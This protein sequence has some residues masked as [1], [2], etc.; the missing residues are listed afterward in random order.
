MTRSSPL[1]SLFDRHSPVRPN[2]KILRRGAIGSLRQLDG[3]SA[4]G[5]LVRRLEGELLAHIG[6]EPSIVERL[7]V[8]QIVKLRLLLDA[9]G[10]KMMNGS[11]SDLDRRCFGA[12][13]NAI[14]L[15]LREIGLK[16]T[17]QAN[18]PL[19]LSTYLASLP[20]TDGA[21]GEAATPPSAPRPNVR[22]PTG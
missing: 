17:A 2:S 5:R 13:H 7:L 11:F 18:Q 21:V 15:A 16:P 4:Q 19:D 20:A 10:E 12:A 3:R 6:H 22:R 1:R 8:D 14:R 9:L